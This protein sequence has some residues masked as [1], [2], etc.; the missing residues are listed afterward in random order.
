MENRL[1]DRS[2]L[3]LIVDD[4][5]TNLSLLAQVL[6]DAGFEVAIATSGERA[7]E[8]VKRERPDLILLDIMMPGIGGLE[9][10]RRLKADPCFNT[11][12]VIFMTA[13]ADV[14][15]KVKALEL[16][17]VDYITK[18]FRESEVVDRV[19]IHLE[20]CKTR[21]ALAQSEK[22]TETVLN[23][24]REVVWSAYLDP[25]EIVYLNPSVEAI[26]G[27]SPQA[28]IDR[29]EQWIERIVEEDTPSV[30]AY[31][32]GTPN[33]NTSDCESF[34]LEYRV[35]GLHGKAHWLQC[36]AKIQ[37]EASTGRF[38]VDGVLYDNTAR[39]LAEQKLVYAA[40]KDSLTDLA[41]RAFFIDK[42]NQALKAVQSSQ[43]AKVALLFID[44][45]RFKN[46]ND[47]LGHSIGD[48]LLVQVS[49]RLLKAVR[50]TDLVARLGGDEFTILIENIYKEE[51]VLTICDRIQDLL[52]QPL[53]VDGYTFTLTASI[54]VVLSADLYRC[55]DDMLR[56]A[57]I[58]MY[59]AK[60]QGKACYQ[61]FSRQMYDQV[62]Y[63][64]SLE[65]ELR[66]ALKKAELFLVYQP[67]LDLETEK[68]SGF[69]A[70]MRWHHPELGMVSPGEFIPLAEEAGLINN[71]G[72]FA[73][74]EACHQMSQWIEA[75]PEAAA[76][77][78][79]IN[80]SSHQLET[81]S[82]P[83]LVDK[84][85]R[86]THLN[87][88]NIKLEVTET[89]LIKNTQVSWENL[90]KLKEKHIRISLDD[91]GTGYSSLSYLIKFPVDTLK[92]DRSFVSTMKSNHSSLEVVRA[93]ITL[94]RTLGMVVVAEGV[95]NVGQALAIR[96]LG[97]D[98]VQG[99][100]FSKPLSVEQAAEY[101]QQ[102]RSS[103]LSIGSVSHTYQL[104]AGRA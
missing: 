55:A 37:R 31:L 57:D 18:P 7:I 28:L 72:E 43:S 79:N 51:H 42:L 69:E 94:A 90:R 33:P 84:T 58:A 65:N 102:S 75:Y 20:L 82:F 49:H 50:P 91:F 21:L 23:S 44:L 93:V 46:V 76:L 15:H 3:I 52:S 73:L 66:L 89:S 29:P 1:N 30:K 87:A 80:V 41:N 81:E 19:A 70:L 38:R 96:G 10:C 77:T 17:A 98:L 83:R 45:D 56:D 74:A 34:E 71:I 61:L 27:L 5:P 2:G 14:E 39:K 64:L 68:L 13:L 95:E 62:A 40:Q 32:C 92:I 104:V 22:R 4:T 53:S 88:R 16:G 99:Y 97:C 9:T 35:I 26:Y 101:I 86:K 103:I 48:E 60:R 63:K 12:P 47:S 24:L 78:M 8:Q 100:L 85:L 25:F 67:I 54:G 6:G 36:H 59:E 11:L